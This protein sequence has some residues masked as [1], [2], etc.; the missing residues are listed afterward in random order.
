MCSKDIS[1]ATGCCDHNILAINR[2]AEIPKV[3]PKEIYKRSYKTFSQ[4]C[5][6]IDGNN[7]CWSDVNKEDYPDNAIKTYFTL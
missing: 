3:K 2:K 7:L 4:E 1:V 6:C 5:F